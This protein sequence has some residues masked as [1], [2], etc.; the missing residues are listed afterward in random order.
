MVVAGSDQRHV[1]ILLATRSGSVIA[2]ASAK[3]DRTQITDIQVTL[4]A[5]LLYSSEAVRPSARPVTSTD[6]HVRVHLF[7]SELAD[8]KAPRSAKGG[9]SKLSNMFMLVSNNV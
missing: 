8:L 4:F 1:Y 5:G 6:V 3:N 7:K 9:I 2:G